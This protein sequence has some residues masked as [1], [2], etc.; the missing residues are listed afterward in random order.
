MKNET[1]LALY[2]AG[3]IS[4]A[5]ID[6]YQINSMEPMPDPIRAA[7]R[8]VEEKEREIFH[9]HIAVSFAAVGGF[10][11]L[12]TM[13]YSLLK[14]QN[15]FAGEESILASP[16]FILGG[17][18][19]AYLIVQFCQGISRPAQ[20]SSEFGTALANLKAILVLNYGQMA[21]MG[22]INLKMRAMDVLLQQAACIK[23]KME[24]TDGDDPQKREFDR[25]FSLL[26]RFGLTEKG[27][28]RGWYLLVGK[29]LHQHQASAQQK[30]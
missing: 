24:K 19:L 5:L 29:N 23:I 7:E 21:K 10:T 3:E 8:A 30:R 18:G 12:C 15:Y 27:K 26:E 16:S 6:G 22:P 25:R 13:F 9:C 17:C 1:L 11:F 2:E 20:T 14:G 4:Q 28:P